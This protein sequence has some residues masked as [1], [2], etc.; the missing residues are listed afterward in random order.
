MNVIDELNNA[1]KNREIEQQIKDIK[2]ALE[3]TYQIIEKQQDLLESLRKTQVI[4]LEHLLKQV[5][6]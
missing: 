1:Q 5:K 6:K 4:I 2:E 3:I